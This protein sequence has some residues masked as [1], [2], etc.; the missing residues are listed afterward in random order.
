M[1]A[2][3]LTVLS[4]KFD[5]CRLESFFIFSKFECEISNLGVE[6]IDFSIS[7]DH[8][9]LEFIDPFLKPV[10]FGGFWEIRRLQLNRGKGRSVLFLWHW[11]GVAEL[12]Y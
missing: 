3:I 7:H 6:F 5:A 4:I 1:F 11:M 9:F 10:V 2:N 8:F 12:E